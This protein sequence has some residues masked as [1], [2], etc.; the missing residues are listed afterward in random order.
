MINEE[1]M[2]KCIDKK[3]H[4]ENYL[5]KKNECFFHQATHTYTHAHIISEK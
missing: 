5:Y 4:V 3:D 2:T 1:L